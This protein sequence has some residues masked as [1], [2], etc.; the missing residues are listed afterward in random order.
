MRQTETSRSFGVRQNK[1]KH[2]KT[3]EGEFTIRFGAFYQ[4]FIFSFFPCRS[5]SATSPSS[6]LAAI[7]RSY[8]IRFTMSS[9]APN[10]TDTHITS[11]WPVV[12]IYIAVFGLA[13]FSFVLRHQCETRIPLDRRW[14]RNLKLFLLIRACAV[15]L[16][17]FPTILDSW[18]CIFFF[19]FVS[20]IAKLA[21]I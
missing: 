1:Q 18:F 2:T 3:C 4:N 15:Q 8:I 12:Y 19:F 11:R 17:I 5:S 21:H 20:A 16:G 13:L 10:E 14:R 9:H 7:R 6:Q